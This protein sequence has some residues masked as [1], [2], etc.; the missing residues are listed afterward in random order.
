MD[1]SPTTDVG[2]YGVRFA[3][4]SVSRRW[5]GRTQRQRATEELARLRAKYPNDDLA[6]VVRADRDAPWVVVE[7]EQEHGHERDR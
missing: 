6:L 4:G 2:Q 7:E 5:N 1:D 3:D